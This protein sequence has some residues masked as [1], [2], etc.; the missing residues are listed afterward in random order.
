MFIDARQPHDL[1]PMHRDGCPDRAMNSGTS[2]W[3]TERIY[4]VLNN[5]SHSRINASRINLKRAR[6]AREIAWFLL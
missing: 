5:D 4:E 6:T 3:Q 2:T 1:E